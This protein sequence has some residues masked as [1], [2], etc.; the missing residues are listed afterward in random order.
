LKKRNLRKAFEALKNY[1]Q[2][3]QRIREFK[4]KSARKS[5]KSVLSGFSENTSLNSAVFK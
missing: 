1:K 4:E 2:V 5:V 3:E